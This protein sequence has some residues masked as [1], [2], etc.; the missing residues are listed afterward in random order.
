MA[1]GSGT[2]VRTQVRPAAGASSADTVAAIARVLLW[3]VALDLVVTRLLVRLSIFVPKDDPWTTVSGLLGRVGAATDV[4]IPIV[5]LLLLVAM[6]ARAGRLADRPGQALLVAVAVIAAGGFALVVLPPTPM[7]VLVLDVLAAGVAVGAGIRAAAAGS[8]RR[9]V[10]TGLV[11]LAAA[12]ALAGASR[13]LVV[14]D[15]VAASGAVATSPLAVAAAV[16]GQLAFVTSAFVLGWAG[17]VAA[18]RA[19]RAAR[20]T[21]VA[22]CVVFGVLFVAGL[23]APQVL[24]ALAIWSSG[25]AGAFPFV[26]T[27]AAAGVTVAGLPVLYRSAPMPAV[28]AAIVLLA[29]FN[30]AASGLVLAGL[31]GLLVSCAPRAGATR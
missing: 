11:L 25:L 19:G 22:G 17:L 12:V 10:R 13:A 4:L 26:V 27:A 23:Q 8:C 1:A 31:L 3:A 7:L 2:M 15:V 18:H 21:I 28:G 16:S 20:G 6:L 9:P 29:G 30:L 24:G 5:G 14:L